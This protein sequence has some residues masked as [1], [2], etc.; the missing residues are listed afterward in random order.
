MQRLYP[1][2]KKISQN[3]IEPETLHCNVSTS[4]WNRYPS[5]FTLFRRRQQALRA[6]TA[7]GLC[8]PREP[9]RQEI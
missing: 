1:S 4:I 8:L 9:L 7:L 2:G 5:K 3:M 6:A